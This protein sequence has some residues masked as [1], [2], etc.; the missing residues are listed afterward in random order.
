MNP[1]MELKVQ[2]H[3]AAKAQDPRTALELY[4]RGIREGKAQA[5]PAI[6]WTLSPSRSAFV[7]HLQTNF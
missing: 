2:M 1:D 5:V 4:D 3:A 6:M 7:R